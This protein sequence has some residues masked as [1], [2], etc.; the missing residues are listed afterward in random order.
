[1]FKKL[2]KLEI[3]T[4]TIAICASLSFAFKF[5]ILGYILWLCASTGFLIYGILARQTYFIIFDII[6][7]IIEIIGIIN[8]LKK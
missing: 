2:K 5:V 1:M 7:L 4:A 3:L 6:N 8:W